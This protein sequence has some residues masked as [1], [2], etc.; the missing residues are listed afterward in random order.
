MQIKYPVVILR[1]DTSLLLRRPLLS[2]PTVTTFYGSP[3]KLFL[4]YMMQLTIL[5]LNLSLDLSGK[6]VSWFFSD[7]SVSLLTRFFL[8]TL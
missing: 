7:L 5:N 1:A 2:G 6:I 8:P 3:I 4:Q